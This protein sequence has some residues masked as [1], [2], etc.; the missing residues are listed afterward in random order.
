MLQRAGS[1]LVDVFLTELWSVGMVGVDSLAVCVSR[2]AGGTIV[3]DV[4]AVIA[5]EARYSV[6]G[7]STG[8]P[9]RLK[10]SLAYTI[11]GYSCMF[12]IE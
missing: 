12:E 6:V 8:F 2:V 5:G 1:I 7:P 10:T 9:L 11:A 4:F 3:I